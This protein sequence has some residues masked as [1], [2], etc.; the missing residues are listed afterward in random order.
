MSI[1]LQLKN[2]NNFGDRNYL[3]DHVTTS[4][5]IASLSCLLTDTSCT[6]IN[7][8]EQIIKNKYIGIPSVVVCSFIKALISRM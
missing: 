1:R 5:S 7:S 2:L 3:I 8:I 4:T 6:P